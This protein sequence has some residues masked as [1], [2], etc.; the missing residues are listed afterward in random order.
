M[1]S[2][3]EELREHGVL[4]LALVR[5]AVKILRNE[6]SISH[7]DDSWIRSNLHVAPARSTP[8]PNPEATSALKRSPSPISAP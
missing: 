7:I 5:V 4:G 1:D 8:Q 2:G 3:S 6:G